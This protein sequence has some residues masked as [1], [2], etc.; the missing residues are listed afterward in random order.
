[1][2]I[3]ILELSHARI[4]KIMHYGKLSTI[5]QFTRAFKGKSLPI[6]IGLPVISVESFGRKIIQQYQSPPLNLLEQRYR[7]QRSRQEL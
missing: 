3:V 4:R 5:V 1:M 6:P 2:P 7:G